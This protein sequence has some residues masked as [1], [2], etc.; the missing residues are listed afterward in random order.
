MDTT[1]NSKC[2]ISFNDFEYSMKKIGFRWTL[3]T[4]FNSILISSVR[5]FKVVNSELPTVIFFLEKI[6]S[7][8]SQFMKITNFQL[9]AQI[10]SC[11]A[12]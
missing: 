9:V 3:S 1:V 6:T 8:S 10:K 11:W 12:L 5:R 4:I 7:Q 2:W